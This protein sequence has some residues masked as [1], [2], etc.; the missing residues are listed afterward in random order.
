MKL[1]KL[2]IPVII[3]IVLC[4]IIFFIG[5]KMGSDKRL[6]VPTNN[7]NNNI[8]NNNGASISGVNTLPMMGCTDPSALN[9]YAGNLNDDGSCVYIEDFD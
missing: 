7:L 6:S 2:D 5:Y 1:D 4:L 3:F 9:F 8:S